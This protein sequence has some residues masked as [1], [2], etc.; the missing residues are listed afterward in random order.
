VA[1][2]NHSS[3]Q[4]IDDVVDIRQLKIARIRTT[5]DLAGTHDAWTA[6]TIQRLQAQRERDRSI[7]DLARLSGYLHSLGW[8]PTADGLRK[9]PDEVTT[10]NQ[11][12]LMIENKRLAEDIGY[13]YSDGFQDGYSAGFG[14]MSVRLREA[15]DIVKLHATAEHGAWIR[16]V[17]SEL[18]DDVPQGLPQACPCG[19]ERGALRHAEGCAHADVTARLPQCPVLHDMD[20]FGRCKHCD[21]VQPPL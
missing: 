10:M 3:D 11:S 6:E 9:L 16:E 21:F 14:D 19:A 8:E 20:E 13:A 18:S 5:L 15:I 17:E 4:Q 7:E 12:E 1:N 2:I